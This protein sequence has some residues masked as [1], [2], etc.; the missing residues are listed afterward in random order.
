M[1]SLLA[2]LLCLTASTLFASDDVPDAPSLNTPPAALVTVMPNV[3]HS[4]VGSPAEVRVMVLLNQYGY[5][6]A[7]KISSSTNPALDDPCLSAIR[8]WRYKP[9]QRNGI[10]VTASFIQPFTFGNDTFDTSSGITSRPKTRR[11]VTPIVPESLKHVSGLVTVAVQLDNQGKI[12]GT[13]VVSSSHEELNP[14]TLDAVQQWVFSP[15]YINGKAVTSSVYVPFEYIGEPLSEAASA[16]KPVVVVDNSELKPLRQASPSVPESLTGLS[17]E[18][19]IEFLIDHKG[20]VADAKVLSATPPALGELARLAALKWKFTPIIKNGVAVPVKA[21][22]PFR[23]GQGTVAIAKIDRLP[24]VRNSVNPELPASLAG[25]SGFANILFDIDAQ[26]HVAA[27]EAKESSHEEFKTAA[28][29][30]ARQWTFKPAL[31]ASVPVAARVVIP[32]VFGKK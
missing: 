29:A 21:V 1:K 15:A 28:L 10:A 2:A 3:S 17:G 24:E 12:T 11:Q 31:R 32:F 18:V 30:A 27:V 19:E 5:V 16:A 8:Q 22:Q 23:F 6:T 7:A 14:P 9:A 4:L 26:G 25:A 20:Y 13:E